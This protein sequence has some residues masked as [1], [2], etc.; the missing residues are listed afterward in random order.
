M[1]EKQAPSEHITFGLLEF[2]TDRLA[3][4]TAA[5]PASYGLLPPT[6]ARTWLGG[7]SGA[8]TRAPKTS[9]DLTQTLRRSSPRPRGPRQ[10]CVPS[11]QS[12]SWPPTT[13]WGGASGCARPRAEL[14]RERRRAKRCPPYRAS[15]RSSGTTCRFCPTANAWAYWIRGGSQR[16]IECG[17]M[18][19]AVAAPRPNSSSFEF[20]IAIR[21]ARQNLTLGTAVMAL[22]VHIPIT[23]AHLVKSGG[24]HNTIQPPHTRHSVSDR[25]GRPGGTH[26][27]PARQYHR[28]TT[29]RYPARAHALA[30]TQAARSQTR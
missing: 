15:C 2:V 26:S 4:V 1:N 16:H 25:L 19:H 5:R 17:A 24:E 10:A 18:V 30:R 14:R 21:D 9:R 23:G 11:A 28:R 13:L 12:A 29:P 7:P 3:G 20:V 27:R 22:T 8:G 6:V